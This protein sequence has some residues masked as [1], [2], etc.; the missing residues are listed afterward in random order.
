MNII[1]KLFKMAQRLYNIKLTYTQSQPCI[2]AICTN[3]III[4][5][6]GDPQSNL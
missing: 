4:R 3:L 1:Q 6:V 2:N 5:Y